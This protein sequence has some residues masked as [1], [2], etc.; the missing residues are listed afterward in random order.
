MTRQHGARRRPTRPLVV[1]LV[2]AL[3]L[4][5]AACGRSKAKDDGGA[6][7]GDNATVQQRAYAR[8]M[9]EHGVDL[10]D[11]P[12][13]QPGSGPLV[14]SGVPIDLAAEK[15]AEAAC[16]QYLP[17]GGQTTKPDAAALEKLRTHAK[18]M[19]GLGFDY[20]DPDPDGNTPPF[21]GGQSSAGG[22][23]LIDAEKQ[24]RKQ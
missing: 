9:R 16:R 24:C 19:R 1:G 14:A 6:D 17:E 7:I 15:V 8:C 20:P 21:T 5:L 12:P 18:C 11:A 4:S 2:L 13:E 3:T 23:S 22:K 10:P